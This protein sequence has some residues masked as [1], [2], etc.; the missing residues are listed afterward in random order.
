[1]DDKSETY[2]VEAGNAELRHYLA[3]L[4]R[5]SRCFS[6]SIKALR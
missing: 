2:S 3:R 1:M 5:K 4:G 6:R